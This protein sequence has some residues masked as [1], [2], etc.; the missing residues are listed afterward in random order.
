[1]ISI[2]VL[3]I[4]PLLDIMMWILRSGCVLDIIMC[5]TIWRGANFRSNNM[6]LGSK[7]RR[8][9]TNLDN[10]KSQTI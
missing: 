4:K 2:Q 1:M 5:I 7:K 8:K 6:I 10:R 3:S 9:E